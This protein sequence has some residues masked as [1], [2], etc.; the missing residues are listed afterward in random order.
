VVPHAG[1]EYS[2]PVAASAFACVPDEV[3]AFH[4]ALLGPSHFVPLRGLAVSAARAWRTP[5]GD[6]PVDDALRSVAV[7]AGATVDEGPHTRDHALEVE[8]PFL[9]RKLDGRLRVL[10]VA[11]GSGPADALSL[12]AALAD[13]A[14]I[15]V[16][17]DLSHYLDESSARIRDLRTSQAVLALDDAAIGDHDAC[18]AHAL[19]GLVAHAR[20]AGWACT[21]LELR[22]SADATG[23]RSQVVGYGAFAFCG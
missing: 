13:D 5:L 2:G 23:D 17:S 20:Q 21:L 3:A 4:V 10:P 15:L 22:S 1:Y 8:L 14:V 9:Q 6:A 18:G 16:S 7:A 19:R 12:V 11:V